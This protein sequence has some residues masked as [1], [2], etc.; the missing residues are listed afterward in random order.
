MYLIAPGG[1]TP[2]TTAGAQNG[3]QFGVTANRKYST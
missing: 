2:L 1:T 3:Y